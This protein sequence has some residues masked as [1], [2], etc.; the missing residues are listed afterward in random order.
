[1]LLINSEINY[2][3][4]FIDY[5]R[6]NEAFE[7][8]KRAKALKD[9]DKREHNKAHIAQIKRGL[10]FGLFGGAALGLICYFVWSLF[11]GSI[12]GLLLGFIVGCLSVKAPPEVYKPFYYETII[13]WLG[14]PLGVL[15][16][17]VLS[18]SFSS[19]NRRNNHLSKLT[20]Y[21]TDLGDLHD[22]NQITER[23][24]LNYYINYSLNGGKAR[25][26]V[27]TYGINLLKIEQ[28]N[29]SRS[30]A[31]AENIYSGFVYRMKLNRPLDYTIRID[32]IENG[33]VQLAE[34]DSQYILGQKRLFAFSSKGMESMFSCMIFPTNGSL[35]ASFIDL[36]K[37][38]GRR[39]FSP[40]E[41]LCLFRSPAEQE[42]THLK[43]QE[44]INPGVEEFLVFLHKKYG[45][46][47][48][49]I[50]DHLNI[51]F[52]ADSAW[53]GI[54]KRRLSSLYN[55]LNPTYK[56]DSDIM[57]SSLLRVYESFMLPFLLGKYF[58][59]VWMFDS[60]RNEESAGVFWNDSVFFEQFI[61]LN[62]VTDAEIDESVREY[63]QEICD[64][65]RQ[66]KPSYRG[67]VNQRQGIVRASN[68]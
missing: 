29:N 15:R 50:N 57:C 14:S 60:A 53:G 36:V 8:F 31:R 2:T 64:A 12:I 62:N 6:S 9:I 51:Q 20:Y 11:I 49:I 43:A 3:Q 61:N 46:F 37:K 52:S 48:L 44:L 30:S 5:Y 28:T 63:Y 67:R 38:E 58:D 55:L 7:M 17:N 32:A 41:L 18:S 54:Q 39:L 10:V 35:G 19:Q 1:V 23:R 4:N 68:R 13:K 66:I 25:I 22:H 45:P 40:S 65:Y 27:G 56:N 34:A 21:N 16:V 42:Y 24:F 33:G 26:P 47:T 59:G